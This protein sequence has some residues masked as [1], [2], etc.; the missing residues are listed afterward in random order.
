MHTEKDDLV[1]AVARGD[2]KAF[3]QLFEE[4]YAPLF[5]YAYN[6]VQD[7]EEAKDIV[8]TA[9]YKGWE[10]R[11]Q[12]LQYQH[13]KSFLYLVVRNAGLNFIKKEQHTANRIQDFLLTEELQT[14]DNDH[15]ATE[16]EVLKK[17]FKAIDG[18]PKKCR[19][20]FRLTYLENKSVQEIA[21]L[22]QISPSNVSAQRHRAL[23]LLRLALT[24]TPLALFY[25][26]IHIIGK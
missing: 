17:V 11:A 23:S 4:F 26:Y 7:K 18:L 3:N 6:L 15:L 12:F 21:T 24:E 13:I 14:T 16:A 5:Y 8:L 20:V 1:K 2:I 25:L 10:R 9:L 22:L 19:E